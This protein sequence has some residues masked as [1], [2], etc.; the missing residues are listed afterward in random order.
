MPKC[1]IDLLC[2]KIITNINHGFSFCCFCRFKL[3]DVHKCLGG[4]QLNGIGGTGHAATWLET[5]TWLPR[6]VRLA[7]ELA[8]FMLYRVQL[9]LKWDYLVVFSLYGLE[10]LPLRGTL[11]LPL[12]STL[13]WLLMVLS[14]SVEKLCKMADNL[15]SSPLQSWSTETT[16]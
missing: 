13:I 14:M 12:P 1:V 9:S 3:S 15:A 7:I 16:W 6:L 8:A 4:L 11:P 2:M 10:T 5:T